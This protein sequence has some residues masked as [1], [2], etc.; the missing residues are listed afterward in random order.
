MPFDSSRYIAAGARGAHAPGSVLRRSPSPSPRSPLCTCWV[1]LR[2]CAPSSKRGTCI[3]KALCTICSSSDAAAAATQGKHVCTP[4]RT[5]HQPPQT[6]G[7]P[8]LNQLLLCPMGAERG[9]NFSREGDAPQALP[10]LLE[11][12]GRVLSDLLS[13]RGASCIQSWPIP[14]VWDGANARGALH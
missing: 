13:E 12:G 6:A 1:H 14:N 4:E 3:R 8:W 5:S 10:W 11:L 2:V 9:P 7:A